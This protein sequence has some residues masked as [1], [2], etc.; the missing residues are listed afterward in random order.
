ME[1]KEYE[2]KPVRR[3]AFQINQEHLIF[4]VE[5]KEAT[6]GTFYNVQDTP[7]L[8]KAYE[9]PKIGDWVVKLT[10]EDTYHCTDKVFRERNI[11]PEVETEKKESCRDS[12]Y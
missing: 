2:S 1:F 6:Y 11:V 7:V 3:L 4:K 5:D 9:E 12:V 8:F 10:E